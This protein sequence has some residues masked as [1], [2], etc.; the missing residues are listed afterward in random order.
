MNCRTMI[1]QPQKIVRGW[2]PECFILDYSEIVWEIWSP[3][4]LEKERGEKRYRDKER[5]KND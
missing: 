2:C 1:Q 4:E 5:E 3:E